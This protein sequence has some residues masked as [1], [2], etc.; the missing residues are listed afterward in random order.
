[1]AQYTKEEKEE[2]LNKFA[3]GMHKREIAKEYKRAVGAIDNLLRRSIGTARLNN[4]IHKPTQ[5]TNL[6]E[7]VSLLEMQIKILMEIVGK[8][9]A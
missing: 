6:E 1:M 3:Q 5:Q 8:Y 2:I 9:E 7:R 4:A